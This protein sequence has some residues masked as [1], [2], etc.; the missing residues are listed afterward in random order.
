M[1]YRLS[2]W[3]KLENSLEVCVN[4][5][6]RFLGQKCAVLPFDF[7]NSLSTDLRSIVE[8]LQLCYGL[9]GVLVPK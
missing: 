5:I 2:L 8:A 3:Q 1:E 4:R 7:L 6:D 9:R